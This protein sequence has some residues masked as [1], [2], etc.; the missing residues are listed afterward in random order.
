MVKAVH[1]ETR[2][3]PINF[4]ESV[5][6][7]RLVSDYAEVLELDPFYNPN[8]ALNNER[9]HG[10]RAFPVDEQIPELANMPKGLS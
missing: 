2:T 6:K 10:L 5:Y 3:R 9:F 4:D 8:L 7:Q 1:Y